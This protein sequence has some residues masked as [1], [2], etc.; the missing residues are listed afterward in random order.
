MNNKKL[1]IA[2][3]LIS[4]NALA[5]TAINSTLF[6]GFTYDDNIS[7]AELSSDIENDSFF[8]IGAS[9]NY[10][11]AINNVSKIIFSASAEYN[12]YQDFDKLDNFK[13]GIAANYQIQP[14][15]GYTAPWYSISIGYKSLGYDP[16]SRDGSFTN[17]GLD[18]GKRITDIL[19]LR[20]GYHIESI[21]T[22]ANPPAFDTDNNQL[23]IN[24]DYKLSSHNTFYTTVSSTDGEIVSTAAPTQKL[25]N[26][27]HGVII[28]DSTVFG[29]NR[30]AYQLKATTIA[31]TLGN[32]Y[33]IS[34][35][36]AIDISLLHYTSSAYGG[37]DY[38]GIILQLTYLHSF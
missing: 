19:S 9:A 12:Q 35:Q 21:D 36:Q 5:A 34:Q 29:P 1:L 4:N 23:Y 2:L 8:N 33:S 13:L 10:N 20:A 24:L 37:N 16:D 30:Y 31:F 18:F 22:E 32:N 14:T 25:I 11:Y 17:I 28:N 7:R 3:T 38:D 15:S 6:A 26:A 27:S